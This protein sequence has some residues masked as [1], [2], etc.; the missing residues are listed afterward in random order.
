M[1]LLAAVFQLCAAVNTGHVDRACP[2]S[3]IVSWTTIIRREASAAGVDPYLVAAVIQKESSFNTRARSS[4]GA[5]GLMQIMPNSIASA[6]LP[7]ERIQH[8][9]K[10]IKLGCQHIKKWV[11]FCK[12]MEGALSTYSGRRYCRPSPYSRAILEAAAAARG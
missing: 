1:T 9:Y 2:T 8:P 4:V 10:N 6:G 12:N 7:A 5:V 3:S 11:G